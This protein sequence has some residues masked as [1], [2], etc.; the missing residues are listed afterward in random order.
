MIFAGEP[1][2]AVKEQR[3]LLPLQESCMGQCLCPIP[4]V[5]HPGWIETW[6]CG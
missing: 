1:F 2:F 5:L 3:L 4:S 6:H